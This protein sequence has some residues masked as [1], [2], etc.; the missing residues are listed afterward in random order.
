VFVIQRSGAMTQEQN[1]TDSTGKLDTKISKN[2]SHLPQHIEE[3]VRAIARLRAEHQQRSTLSERLVDRA[4]SL[5]GRPAFVVVL[6]LVVV[7]WGGGNLLLVHTNQFAFDAPPFP[8][9]E[10]GLTLMALYMGALI[11]TTQR[12]ADQLGELRE[13]M[14]LEL[15]ILTEQKVAKLIELIEELRRDSPEI[16]DRVDYEAREMAA[17]AD[18]HEVLGAIEESNQKMAAEIDPKPRTARS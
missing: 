1:P 17:P 8:W 4:T 15:A 7:L 16:R 18:P 9:L 13:E 5:F 10:D 2:T 12:R 14:T 11:L 3:A 6:S